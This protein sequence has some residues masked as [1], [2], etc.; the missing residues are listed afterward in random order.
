MVTVGL[1]RLHFFVGKAEASF[2]SLKPQ[3]EVPATIRQHRLLRH[4]TNLEGEGSLLKR[5]LHLTTPET[6]QV[7]AGLERATVGA[8][9]GY[10][11][12]LLEEGVW[13][14][15]EGKELRGEDVTD[16]R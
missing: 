9:E 3:D 2:A 11:T 5:S 1:R 7:T 16:L 8:L 13:V 15:G 14:G 10:V 4:P 12:K 6:T